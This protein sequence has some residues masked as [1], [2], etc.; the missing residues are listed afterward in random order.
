[1]RALPAI[2]GASA[3]FLYIYRDYVSRSQVVE[4][5]GK[6]HSDRPFRKSSETC[7][8]ALEREVEG[9]PSRD[10]AS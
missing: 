9:V 2:Y 3:P 7:L 4:C 1:M 8:I 10:V 5:V 6:E